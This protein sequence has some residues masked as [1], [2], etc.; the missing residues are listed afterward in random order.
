MTPVLR[1]AI[2]AFRASGDAAPVHAL[3]PYT[4]FVGLRTV[5]DG[6]VLRTILAARPG[7]VGNTQLGAVH[8]G[9]VGALL[10]HAAIMQL[11]FQVDCARPPKTINVSIDYLRPCLADRETIATAQVVKQGRR[12]ANVRV[13]AHQGDSARLIAAAHAHFLLG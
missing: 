10:E 13:E 9:V 12:I 2:A 3:I 6:A 8:G 4:A 7:N 1:D 11:F 5:A